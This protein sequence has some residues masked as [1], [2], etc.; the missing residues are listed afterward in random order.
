MLGS[1][2]V[3]LG[4]CPALNKVCHTKFIDEAFPVVTTVLMIQSK[5]TIADKTTVKIRYFISNLNQS[6]A[7]FLAE[8]RSHW[9]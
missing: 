6:S 5:R 2:S 8:I 9:E 7:W 4:G 1:F 3:I